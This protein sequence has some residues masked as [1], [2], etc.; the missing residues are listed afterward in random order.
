MLSDLIYY[1][2]TSEKFNYLVWDSSTI[3]FI[4]LELPDF[5][6]GIFMF[7]SPKNSDGRSYYYIGHSTKL[8]K[9]PIKLLNK[10]LRYKDSIVVFISAIDHS[11]LRTDDLKWIK[12]SLITRINDAYAV[13]E[14]GGY[15][16]FNSVN[17]D[18]SR[19][20]Y[21]KTYYDEILNIFSQLK[22]YLPIVP[23]KPLGVNEL[24]EDIYPDGK[25]FT[26]GRTIEVCFISSNRGEGNFIT[27]CIRKIKTGEVLYKERI[28]LEPKL[29][30]S[31]IK[32]IF[33]K[34]NLSEKDLSINT[35]NTVEPLA[36]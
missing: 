14:G 30:V 22:I 8:F 13:A 32:Q 5:T 36:S 20:E 16:Y 11:V 21:L 15:T 2:Y 23:P 6:S 17:G 25:K 31:L 35:S 19:Q 24:V 29:R 27:I 7:I 26:L 10:E 33:L 9:Y 34:K 3:D 1:G 28:L 4:E 12:S 18:L